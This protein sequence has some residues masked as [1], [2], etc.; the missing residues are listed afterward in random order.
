[1]AISR[2]KDSLAAEGA[3]E[4]LRRAKGCPRRVWFAAGHHDKKEQSNA[5]ER[6]KP[7]GLGHR[8]FGGQGGYFA[9][10]DCQTVE[11][12]RRPPHPPGARPDESKKVLEF[13]KPSQ[14]SHR[15]S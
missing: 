15:F 12:A 14:M 5:Y 13:R 8:K 6:S 4:S 10:S 9:A 2:S 3:E 1:M 11:P 7:M